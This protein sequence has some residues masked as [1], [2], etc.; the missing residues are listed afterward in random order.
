MEKISIKFYLDKRHPDAFACYKVNCRVRLGRQDVN[1]YSL[2][3]R[4][5]IGEWDQAKQRSQG[6]GFDSARANTEIASFEYK[7]RQAYNR[8]LLASTDIT[9][10]EL[11]AAIAG[12]TDKA[13]GT[14]LA[15]FDRFMEYQAG[16]KRQGLSEATMDVYRATYKLLQE[17][18]KT[19]SGSK[20]ATM[21]VTSLGVMFAK[22]FA[23]YMLL[24]DLM[25]STV[26]LYFSKLLSVG[27]YIVEC[28][29]ARQQPF[30]KPKIRAEQA[31]P[32]KNDF[33][34]FALL[35]AYKPRPSE[36]DAFMIIKL[37][38]FTGLSIIDALQ[39]TWAQVQQH[40]GVKMIVCHRQK[41]HRAGQPVGK[42]TIVPVLDQAAEVLAWMRRRSPNQ[43]VVCPR[44]STDTINRK[45]TMICN[46]LG[47]PKLTSHDMRKCFTNYVCKRAGVTGLALS[48]SLGHS[49]TNTTEKYYLKD[50]VGQLVA[51]FKKVQAH[52]NTII[53]V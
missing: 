20:Y 32:M 28:G 30:H 37:Q 33:E 24:H 41:N 22:D 42:A 13:T 43:L 46:A 9:V 38:A 21:P 27:E 51:E 1:I 25:G 18:L 14:V 50:D 52:A 11:R 39:L 29:G 36:I 3:V 4:V 19:K 31:K 49:S 16:R 48:A 47:I 53:A 44:V 8:C 12:D 40:E 2:G 23:D 35:M 26:N 15:Y 10:A 5:F 7:I 34:S 6:K 45:L 17:Y